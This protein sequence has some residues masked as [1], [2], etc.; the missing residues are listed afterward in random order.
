MK[1]SGTRDGRI[2]KGKWEEG[3]GRG[4]ENGKREKRDGFD[5]MG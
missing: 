5:G 4:K 3:M 1:G 2:S